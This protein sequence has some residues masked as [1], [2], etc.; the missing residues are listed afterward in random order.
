MGLARVQSARSVRSKGAMLSA[1]GGG[2][3]RKSAGR[4]EAT[5]KV[6]LWAHLCPRISPIALLWHVRVRHA[7][8]VALREGR[9]LH[10]A[11]AKR[12]GR[13]ERALVGSTGTDLGCVFERAGLPAGVRAVHWVRL[14]RPTYARVPHQAR[15]ALIRFPQ[16]CRGS[17]GRARHT[18]RAT[19]ENAPFTFFQGG[20]PMIS[21]VYQREGPKEGY[22]GY[23]PEGS[24]CPILI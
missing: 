9:P 5:V 17:G 1:H 15:Q 18:S 2:T 23:F 11:A 4:K 10:T 6:G 12:A 24:Y 22:G 8:R 14:G 21:P 16:I 13:G 19:S 20:A 3:G 7:S